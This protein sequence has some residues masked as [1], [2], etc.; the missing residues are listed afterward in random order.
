MVQARPDSRYGV[1]R[2]QQLRINAFSS[3]RVGCCRRIRLRVA[4]PC[5]SFA[6]RPPTMERPPCPLMR[7]WRLT[8]FYLKERAMTLWRYLLLFAFLGARLTGAAQPPNI[9]FILADDWGI[10]DVKCYGGERCQIETPNMDRLASKG[11]RF[12]DAHSPSSVCTPT[13]YSVLTGRYSWRSELKSSVLYGFS[14]PLIK[15]SRQT[16]AQYLK[17]QGYHTACIGK[18][19]L[20]MTFP[21]TD[22]KPATCSAKTPEQLKTH[23]NV[24]W[25]G[26]IRNGP[27]AVGF[28]SYPDWIRRLQNR[29]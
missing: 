9:V 18:W 12:T 13:R 11:M 23:C 15:P 6:S 7:R 20:G 27:T 14:P 1:K 25:R 8:T 24:D 16:V 29:K 22:G 3:R 21:T 4:R 2:I 5:C 28:D 10:G 26:Q 17:A 19:H